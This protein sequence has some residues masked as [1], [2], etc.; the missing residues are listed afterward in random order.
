MPGARQALWMVR[1]ADR[2]NNFCTDV[3]GDIVNT[4][5]GAAAGT[6]VARLAALHPDISQL[7]TQILVISGVAAITVGGKAA[8]KGVAIHHAEEV[9][10]WAANLLARLHVLPAADNN[11][12]R[13]PRR[14]GRPR[15]SRPETTSQHTRVTKSGQANTRRKK[16]Q[17]EAETQAET[18]KEE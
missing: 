3:V 14:S 1:H 13:R 2:V 15:R 11:Q 16:A 8:A 12:H 4:L 5:S 17:P 6:I 9:V 18:E 10:S 7:A